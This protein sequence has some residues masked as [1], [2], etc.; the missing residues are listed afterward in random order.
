MCMQGA[1]LCVEKWSEDFEMVFNMF[2][3]K[4]CDGGNPFEVRVHY[5]KRLKDCYKFVCVHTLSLVIYKQVVV[6][7]F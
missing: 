2:N 4:Q 3:L 1:S 6:Y 5:Y 7:V